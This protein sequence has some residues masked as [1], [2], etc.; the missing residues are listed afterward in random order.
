MKKPEKKPVSPTKE[1]KIRRNGILVKYKCDLCNLTRER[2]SSD[3]CVV[4]VAKLICVKDRTEMR[5]ETSFIDEDGKECHR[6]GF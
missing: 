5:R 2:F 6:A 3:E 1:P 4:E